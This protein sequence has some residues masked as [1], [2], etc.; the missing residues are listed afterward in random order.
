MQR[1][2]SHTL[3]EV[4]RLLDFVSD[5]NVIAGNTHTPRDYTD[6]HTWRSRGLSS[7]IDYILYDAAA[8][9][10]EVAA[11]SIDR[12]TED[13]S[14]AIDRSITIDRSLARSLARSIDRSIYRSISRSV[15]QKVGRSVGRAVD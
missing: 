5:Q 6:L 12:P 10:G 15:G 4:T 1:P 11:H 2:T 14:T 7:Q 8:F 13:R 9:D 3:T